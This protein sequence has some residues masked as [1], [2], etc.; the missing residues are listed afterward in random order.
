MNEKDKSIDDINDNCLFL[1]TTNTTVITKQ[2]NRCGVS[3]RKSALN[4]ITLFRLITVLFDFRKHSLTSED[5]QNLL[6]D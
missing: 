6:K 4:C 3:M 5:E 2:S 1:F